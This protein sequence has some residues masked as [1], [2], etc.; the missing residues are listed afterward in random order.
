MDLSLNIWQLLELELELGARVV[1]VAGDGIKA[2][3]GLGTGQGLG[4]ALKLELC[5]RQGVRA[6]T[7]AEV[8]VWALARALAGTWA[9][10]RV[11]T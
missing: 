2:G 3:L 6:V 4:M 9:A 7:V 11:S 5:S 1:V 10:A 8:D